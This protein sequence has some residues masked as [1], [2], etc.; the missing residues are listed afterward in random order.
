MADMHGEDN[1]RWWALAVLCTALL[2]ITLDNTILNVAIPA[3]VRD[4]DASTSQLQWIIDGYTLVFAGLLLTL[5]SVGD[6]FG[7]KGA[8]MIGL[9][10]FGSGSTL[11]AFTGSANQLIFTRAAMGI[12]AALI[13]PSTLSLLTNIFRDPRERGRAIGAWAAVAG[14]SGAFGPV[15]GGVLLAHFSWGSIF[16]VNVPIVV[17]AL[18]GSWYLLPSSRDADAPRLDPLGALLSIAG[19]VAVLWS[20]IEA[21]SKGWTNGTV[22]AGLAL[23]IGFL[24][25][26]VVWELRTSHPMLDVRFFNNRRFTAANIAITLV[27]FAMFGQAFLATQY[28]QTVLGFSPLESGVRM[29][30]MAVLMAS[31]APVAPRLVER[32]GTKL[33]VGGGLITVLVGLLVLATV[34]VSNGY[35]HL[36]IGFLF[37]ATGMAMTM[38]PATESIMGSLPP[39]KAGVGSAMNDTTRQMGGALGVAILGSVFATVYRPGIADRVASLGL[40]GDQLSKA[41]DSIGGAVQVAGTLPSESARL[42]IASAKAEFVN[43]MHLAIYVGVGVIAVAAIIVFAYLPARAR[44]AT[45]QVTGMPVDPRLVAAMDRDLTIAATTSS[46][47]TIAE[48]PVMSFTDSVEVGGS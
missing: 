6:R 34:P 17:I 10:I 21:P 8:L 40:A 14:A 25:G 27:F 43:G 1:K 13:M 12:G 7:R 5:G 46:T 30:P 9:V 22:L 2:I 39:A 44:D 15:I 18:I 37:V 42:L 45:D 3:L 38:A 20:I 32:I 24:A 29:L 4:L 33:V 48:A 11:S 47:P 16:F 19:L 35:I 41:Q 26:F 23:G 36:L 31:L 28:L